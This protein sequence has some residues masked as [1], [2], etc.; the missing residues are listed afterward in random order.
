MIKA[1]MNKR[2][3]KPKPKRLP[4]RKPRKKKLKRAANQTW[5]TSSSLNSV[6]SPCIPAQLTLVTTGRTSILEQT[7]TKQQARQLT[8]MS[9]IGSK[10]IMT[11][12]WNSTTRRFEISKP[13]SSRKKAS[14][15]MGPAPLV[16]SGS[17]LST[18]G[19]SAE[20]DTASPATCFS[21]KDAKRSL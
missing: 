12:G 20:V 13:R 16:A 8:T 7:T 6:E 2:I 18:A 17:L 5:K 14:V 3:T 1:T 15:A 10:P 19:V 9:R 11:T 21:M 4:R